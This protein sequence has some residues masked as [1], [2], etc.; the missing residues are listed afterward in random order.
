MPGSTGRSRARS[1]STSS[2]TATPCGTSTTAAS[3]RA[4]RRPRGG[5]PATFDDVAAATDLLPRALDEAGVARGT[6]A[7]VGHSAGGALALWLAAR[8]SLPDGAPGASPVVVPD[9]VVSQAGVDDLTEAAEQGAGGGAV[10]DLMGGTPAAV[11]DR[12]DLADPARLVPLGVPTLVVTG[13]DDTTVPPGLTTAYG[14]AARA[15]G[16]DVTVEVVPGEEHLDQL[17]P[18]SRS[19]RRTREWLDARVVSPRPRDPSRSRSSP[20]AGRP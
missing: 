2:G 10:E 18:A 19:W 14:E 3:A 16:D 9:L 5:W 11:G 4:T 15:A 20:R 13:A 17:D 7:V 1:P 12:Y 8:G 6:V